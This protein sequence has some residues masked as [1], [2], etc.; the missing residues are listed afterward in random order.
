MRRFVV[1][2]TFGALFAAL[3][4]VACGDGNKQPPL[5]PDPNVP[6]DEAGAPSTPSTTTAP[7]ATPPAK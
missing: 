7:P 5:T 3:S 1:L 6:S 4:A 2:F